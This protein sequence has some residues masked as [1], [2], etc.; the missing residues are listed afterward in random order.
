[1]EKVRGMDIFGKWEYD[2]L[3]NKFTTRDYFFQVYGR[4]QRQRSIFGRAHEH[5]FNRYRSG[6]AKCEE[7]KIYEDTKDPVHPFK[8]KKEY[9][10]NPVFSPIWTTLK[11]QTDARR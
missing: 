2:I 8:R 11:D 7:F 9:R 5:Y 10:F 3:R 1:M 4:T 6:K